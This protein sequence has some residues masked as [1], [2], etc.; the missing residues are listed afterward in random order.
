MPINVTL[1]RPYKTIYKNNQI[2]NHPTPVTTNNTTA[3]L[4]LNLLNF[5]PL[6]N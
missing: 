4:Y 2:S 6:I 5:T 1:Y 3:L